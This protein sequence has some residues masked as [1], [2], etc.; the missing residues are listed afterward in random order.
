[1]ATDWHLD[2]GFDALALCHFTGA[3]YTNA[4]WYPIVDCNI[5]NIGIC[6]IKQCGLYAEEY[7]QWIAQVTTTPRIA[8]ML[9]TFKTF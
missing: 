6:V 4:T 1:M 3:A 9:D 2:N 7:K 5:I 8:K